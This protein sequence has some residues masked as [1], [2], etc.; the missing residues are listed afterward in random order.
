MLIIILYINDIMIL[1]DNP[2]CITQIKS[3]LSNC[4]EMTDLSEIDSYLGVQI[5]RDR[6]S[7][8]LEIDQSHYTLEIVN[9]FG[10]SDAYTVHTPLPTGADMHLEKYDGQASSADIKLFQ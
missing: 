2:K 4:Y 1:G 9:H 7:K 3:T 10:L 6:S 5:K 8:Q